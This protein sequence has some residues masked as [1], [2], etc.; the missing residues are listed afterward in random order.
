MF[1]KVISPDHVYETMIDRGTILFLDFMK[2]CYLGTC[3][4]IF[5]LEDISMSCETYYHWRLVM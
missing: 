4:E 2:S 3:Y 1:N 5:H